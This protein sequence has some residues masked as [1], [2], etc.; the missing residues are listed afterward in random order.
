MVDSILFSLDRTQGVLNIFPGILLAFGN[1]AE[2]CMQ[3]R[4]ARF[5]FKNDKIILRQCSFPAGAKILCSQMATPGPA[6]CTPRHCSC[7]WMR[8]KI[9][10][11][12]AD[13]DTSYS[14]C[15]HVLALPSDYVGEPCT[16][17]VSSV[18][19]GKLSPP[20]SSMSAT[21]R[22]LVRGLVSLQPPFPRYDTKVSYVSGADICVL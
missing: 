12:S 13:N 7:I 11:N 18:T 9:I 3:S 20:V 8:A 17:P 2:Q 5:F 6:A 21:H 19:T 4:L 10:Y 1:S 16:V 22:G 15:T 14:P